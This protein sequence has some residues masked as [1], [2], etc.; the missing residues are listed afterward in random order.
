MSSVGANCEGV[1]E[2]KIK[3]DQDGHMYVIPAD[4]E[5]KFDVD[6]FEAYLTEN[7]DEFISVFSKYRKNPDDIKL[8]TDE[9]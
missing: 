5:D 9:I 4:M 1:I 3:E 7:Y 6:I 2:V 8:Y